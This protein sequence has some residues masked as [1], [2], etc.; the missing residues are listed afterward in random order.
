MFTPTES[1]ANA[2]VTLVLYQSVE[3]PPPLQATVIGAAVAAGTKIK[4]GKQTRN[5]AS[6]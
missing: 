4:S 5:S 6:G 1:Q 2:T 3:H